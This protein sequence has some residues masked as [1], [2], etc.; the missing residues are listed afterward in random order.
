MSDHTPTKDLALKFIEYSFLILGSAFCGFFVLAIFAIPFT[1]RTSEE[2]FCKDLESDPI[3]ADVY[4][5]ACLDKGYN[6]Q[7]DRIERK[8]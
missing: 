6:P 1:Y 5:W 8:E 7:T 4:K 2:Y 3:N